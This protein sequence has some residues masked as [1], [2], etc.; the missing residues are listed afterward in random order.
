MT[1]AQTARAFEL[2]GL[3]PTNEKDAVRKAYHALVKQYH[4]DRF[5]PGG[6]QD[7]AQKKLIEL[8]LAYELAMRYTE[9]CTAAIFQTMPP[10]QAKA[11]AKRLLEQGEPESALRHLAR[12]ESKDD[13]WYHLEG[14]VMMQLKQYAAAHQS[15]R[16]AVRRSPENMEYRRSALEAALAVKRRGSFGGRA[17][18]WA[19]E[20][21]HRRRKR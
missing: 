6:E 4:P 2:L 21:F 17:A 14:Q 9:R 8:N 11:Q 1:D 18:E 7:A 16:E 12:A 15:F 13:E 5:R 19:E 3:A 20:F 10:V